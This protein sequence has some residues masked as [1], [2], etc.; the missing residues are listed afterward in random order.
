V[1]LS[2]STC[3]AKDEGHLRLKGREVVCIDFKLVLQ[4]ELLIGEGRVS[5][6]CEK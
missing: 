1:G 5:S 6:I 3:T 4:L 2:V